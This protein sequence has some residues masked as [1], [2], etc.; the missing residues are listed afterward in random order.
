[1]FRGLGGVGEGGVRRTF[2]GVAFG[3]RGRIWRNMLWRNDLTGLDIRAA[4]HV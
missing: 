2:Y 3:V 1:M 4:P